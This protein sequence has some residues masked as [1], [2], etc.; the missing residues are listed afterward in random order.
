VLKDENGD[1]LIMSEM[2]KARTRFDAR[3]KRANKGCGIMGFMGSGKSTQA[4]G[5]ILDS[6]RK[7]KN[8][9]CQFIA[10]SDSNAMLR[11][12]AVRRYIAEDEDFKALCGP[13]TK[14]DVRPSFTQKG[15]SQDQWAQHKFSVVRG[16][17]SIEPTMSAYG[18]ESR[19]TGSRAHI[20]TY[21]DP[22]DMENS[23]TAES[24]KKVWNLFSL[25][26]Q[27]RI[28]PTNSHQRILGTPYYQ[29]DLYDQLFKN[30]KWRWLKQPV[31]QELDAI[32]SR[33]YS[34]GVLRKEER[35]PLP[36][37]WTKAIMK[38]RLEG[39]RERAFMQ[40]YFLEPFSDSDRSFPH[41]D[42]C[43]DPRLTP[44]QLRTQRRWMYYI[45]VD[46]AS[47]KRRG[48]AIVTIGL[49]PDTGQIGLMDVVIG[50]FHGGSGELA[51]MA[52]TGKDSGTSL[53][54]AYA[55]VYNEYGPY[56][57]MVEN[58]AV[59]TFVVESL[60]GAKIADN[61]S[62]K[63]CHTGR[64]KYSE[65]LGLPVLDVEFQNQRWIVPAGQVQ[66]HTIDCA[67]SWCILIR[68][69]KL[70]PNAPS[71]DGVMGLWFAWRGIKEHGE[72][73]AEAESNTDYY[74]LP[75]ADPVLESL[76]MGGD[77]DGA[78]GILDDLDSF[79]PNW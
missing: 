53:I 35:F 62:I 38:D 75:P 23:G 64:N 44:Q 31:T 19:G 73:A 27:S 36:P 77:M 13:G 5:W 63:A 52:P 29:G 45:G 42:L 30:Y 57:S 16:S 50:K 32:I 12:M 8:I 18:M 58:N 22:V 67:C 54:Q 48:T 26:W 25:K 56:L 37:P 51:P 74:R 10:N 49:D 9:Q 4:L 79:E 24:R 71:T 40:A 76:R 68:E 55:S 33:E 20:Q 69:L 70:H 46:P 15:K 1:A 6:I 78:P 72:F 59:Q 39:M 47:S 11:L 66:G 14:D 61:Y 65:T 21:D 41:L 2:H 34:H 28:L 3:C 7:N 60:Q 43:I 17:K